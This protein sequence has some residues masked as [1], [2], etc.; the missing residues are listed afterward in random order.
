MNLATARS[1]KRAKEIGVRKVVGS[2]RG[3]LIR[4]FL[5]ES[6]VL[7]L[8]AMLLSL[9]LTHLLLPAYNIFTVKQI[10]SPINEPSSWIA[11]LCLTLFTSLVAGAY[12]ALF[13]SS[14]KPV[15][16]LKGTVRFSNSSIWFR[17]GLAVFQFVIS[18]VLLIVTIVISQQ[19]SY[20]QNTHLGYD[21]ENLI[22][23]RIEGELMD[24]RNVA[25]NYSKY[26][27][28]KEMALSMPGIAAVDR[29]SEAP[30]AMSF[31][32][33]ESGGELETVTG[34]DAIQ[35]EGKERGASAGFKPMSV[36]FDFLKTM[37]LKIA[38]G[39][40]FS[41]DFATDSADAFMVNEEAVRQMGMKDPIGKWVSAW[42]KKGHIIG[43]LKDYHTGS[44]HE[45][46]KPL[47]IDIKEYEYF[48]V[49]II[50]TEP[51][52]T[53][54]ALAS[55]E[56]VYKDVNPNYP[57]GYQFLDQEYEKLYRNE[58]VIAKLSNAFALIAILISCLGLLGLVMFT[59]EQRTKEFGIR[60]VLGAT[61]SNIVKLLSQDFLKI[62]F[63]SFCIGAPI[64]AYFMNQ[65][66][67]RF[68]FKIDL[69]WWIFAL[70]GGSALLIALITIAAQAIQS[71]I[72]NPIKS[73]RTE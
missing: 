23:M 34:D 53:K 10:S 13:L 63:L 41:R 30:H 25:K 58:A 17:K 50:R 8:L 39:R 61:V 18:I 69:S 45:P 33:D 47:I 73:L 68:A 40:G 51:G 1:L 29:S 9:M 14:L 55:L 56:K 64:A 32:V 21:K 60:K 46:I 7:S 5:G 26:R 11:L 20:V 59:A 71:A 48:G 44:L 72:A 15:R 22:Y 65:W 16:I 6:L 3:S 43:I 27:L 66:L 12:P 49:M 62:V 24:P 57:F 52:K 19:T 38:D 37:N 2:S 67:Q 54:E 28:F 35:W 4:Q 70:A 42:K 31:V 36:G